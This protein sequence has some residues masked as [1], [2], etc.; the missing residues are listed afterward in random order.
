MSIDEDLLVPDKSLSIL[1]GAVTSFQSG[2]TLSIYFKKL[3]SVCKYYNIDLSKPVK[4]LTK[5]EFNTIFYGSKDKIHFNVHT[6]SG[7]ILKSYD[8]FEGIITN[9]E[10]RY[11]ETNSDWIREWIDKFMIEL[12]CPTC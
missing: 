7:S 1:N 4:D 2:E 11:I 10:R 3:D 12:P 5:D 8:Y 9:L 6:R